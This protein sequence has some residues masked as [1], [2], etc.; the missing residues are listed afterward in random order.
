MPAKF[1]SYKISRQLSGASTE[2]QGY[3]S[4]Q[5]ETA[6]RYVFECSWEVV[7]KVSGIYTVIRSKAAV[8]TG[9][10]GDQYC[11]L[12]PYKEEIVKL[13]VEELEPE[14]APM[15]WTLDSMTSLGF[16]VTYGRWLIEGYPKV[17]LFDIGSAAWKLD[18][19]K[20]EIWERCHIGFPHGDHE[21]NDAIIFGFLVAIFLQTFTN[22]LEDCDHLVCAHFHEWQAGVGLILSRLWK[23]NVSTVFTTHATLLGRHICAGGADLYNNLH[24]FDVDRESGERGIY[25]RHCLERAAVH[26]THVFTTVSDITGLESEHLL[27]RKP[28]L[29][30]PNGLNVLKFTAIHEFQNLH[31]NAKQQIHDF[32]RGHFY[33]HL[34]FDLDKTIYM[35][36]AGRYEFTNKGGDLFI[37]SLARLNHILKSSTDP[38]CK[39]VTV[40]A[41]IIYPARTNSFNAETLKGQAVSKQLKDIIS[42][43]QGNVASRMFESCLGGQIPE[44]DD[45]LYPTE[46]VQLKRCMAS[47]KR[48][49]LPPICTHNMLDDADDPV[50]NA[51][52][53]TQ[54][55]NHQHDRVK[56]IFHPEFLSSASPLIG[57]DYEDFVRGCHLG[58]FPS[59]Y[60]PWGYTPAECTVMGVPSVT[61]NL[62]GFGCFIQDNVEQPE[63][64]GAFVLDRRFR[65]QNES[66]DQLT[67]VLY[68][69]SCLNRRQRVILRNRSERLCEL[70]DW[71]NLG[72]FYRQARKM[73]FMKTH[74]DLEMNL[75]EPCQWVSR[76]TSAPTI[77]RT[78]R[79]KWNMKTGFDSRIQSCIALYKSTSQISR[80]SS[81]YI[82]IIYVD[83]VTWKWTDKEH[84]GF[85]NWAPGHNDIFENNCLGVERSNGS[86][87]SVR[88]YGLKPY[89]RKVPVVIP[90]TC[91]RSFSLPH[92]IPSNTTAELSH[93]DLSG[94]PEMEMESNCSLNAMYGN[95]QP[96]NNVQLGDVPFAIG[97]CPAPRRCVC[98]ACK[99]YIPQNDI[100]ISVRFPSSQYDGLADQWHHEQ[101]F[102][103]TLKLDPQMEINERSIKDFDWLALS[104]QNRITKEIDKLYPEMVEASRGYQKKVVVIDH[105][106][107][108]IMACMKCGEA[109]YKYDLILK[110]IGYDY[111]REFQCLHYECLAMS[112]MFQGSASDFIG[113][114]DLDE[115]SQ[116]YLQSVFDYCKEQYPYQNYANQIVN[117]SNTISDK[118][119]PERI[120]NRELMEQQNF[121]MCRIRKVLLNM[122][123]SFWL[124]ALKT[125]DLIPPFTE[126]HKWV[127][128]RSGTNSGEDGA[129]IL[130]YLTDCIQFGVPRGCGKCSTPTNEKFIVF[131]TENQTYKCSGH[132]SS[133]T[134]CTFAERNPTRRPITVPA[135]MTMEMAEIRDIRPQNVRTYSSYL[136]SMPKLLIGSNAIMNNGQ[137][138]AKQVEIS[139]SKTQT[140]HVK[141]GCQVDSLALGHENLHVYLEPGA[142]PQPW[143]C[144]LSQTNLSL[145]KNSVFKAQLLEHDKYNRYFIFTCSGSVGSDCPNF[146]TRMYDDDLERAKREFCQHFE[147]RTGNDWLAIM[148]GFP[149]EK[150]PGKYN[151]VVTN[152]D[153]TMEDRSI[154]APV[155]K[156]ELSMP[157]RELVHKMFDVKAMK[158]SLMSMD[159]DLNRLPLKNLSDRQINAA[160][161][162]LSDLEKALNK[163]TPATAEI[164]LDLTNQFYTLIPHDTGNHRPAVISNLEV[165]KRKTEMLDQLRQVAQSYMIASQVATPDG[166]RIVANYKTLKCN[167]VELSPSG[168]EYRRL[169]TYA[170]NTY[171]GGYGQNGRLRITHIYRVDREAEMNRVGGHN[172]MLL[173][174]GSPIS[175][176]VGILSRGL[177]IAPKEAP[178][179][180]YSLGKGIYFAD[181]I[182]KSLGYCRAFYYNYQASQNHNEEAF[183]L[184]C[185]V[186]LNNICQSSGRSFGNRKQD[187]SIKYDSGHGPSMKDAYTDYAMH[188]QGV[189]IPMGKPTSSSGGYNEY[190]VFNEEQVRLRYLVRV[191]LEARLQHVIRSSCY[192]VDDRYCPPLNFIPVDDDTPGYI[193][194]LL[195]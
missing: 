9:E 178:H 120:R 75:L 3:V 23:L 162:V 66:I 193:W 110:T 17:V 182:A 113:Y 187:E 129:V 173:W 146:N 87:I 111:S 150:K 161:K 50:L 73:A 100:R 159:I 123:S 174:H 77:K 191:K 4:D 176:F 107:D 70:L 167:I 47:A 192:L 109:P 5:R 2:D 76:A 158:N 38:R 69:Y 177:K 134:A 170:Q 165:V 65:N 12:G 27:K 94:V 64:Y 59:Y 154:E 37:E 183:L 153:V 32:V 102:W 49:A 40:V 63:T 39:D 175:N 92:S 149:F 188:P 51:L 97:Y 133:Y 121:N 98:Y 8:S 190:V 105:V 42:N 155:E 80:F 104:D 125:N 171:E 44:R 57:L 163:H 21:S 67:Q 68:D 53:R 82:A 101:C 148:S 62:S 45:L 60:E 122:P 61:T 137:M 89:A 19:W 169:E 164:F 48:D 136:A 180:G 31:E 78:L 26:V 56:V 147:E 93:C 90:T 126:A 144:M 139:R 7:N 35:F 33:G 138:V 127:S 29:I 181:M 41:F 115:Q 72:G 81:L 95:Q 36:T 74:P 91:P 157:V 151:I 179:T 184:L 24:K 135:S 43:I 132:I 11:M 99:Q 34:N 172:R 88:C 103:E 108:E 14:T 145:N 140:L 96:L 20:H 119:R 186:A 128:A 55:F 185:E 52:R 114:D 112:G 142:I 28:D 189:V 25:H 16:T 22:S 118:N 124:E 130:N 54:L 6:D 117:G 83:F 116:L 46:V 143:E 166:E 131:D 168:A 152:V 84:F 13:E 85:Q 71:K 141:N 86:L 106:Y 10:L 79:A 195:D 156:G 58:V 18:T 15:K 30:A 194:L 160:Y 1:S